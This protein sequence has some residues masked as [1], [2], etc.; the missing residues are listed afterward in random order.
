[1]ATRLSRLLLSAA[2]VAAM[3]GLSAAPAHAGWTNHN[4][5]LLGDGA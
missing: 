5:T 3:V 1:M 4:D 2:T